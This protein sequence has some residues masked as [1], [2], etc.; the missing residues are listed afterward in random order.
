MQR[1]MADRLEAEFA[2]IRGAAHAPNVESPAALLDVLVP[3]WRTWLRDDIL[4]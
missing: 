3:T 1:T 2:A 4:G